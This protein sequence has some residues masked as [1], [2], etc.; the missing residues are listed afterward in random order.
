MVYQLIWALV[1]L[2]FITL[3]VLVIPSKKGNPKANKKIPALPV[4]L[5][6]ISVLIL[7]YTFQSMKT[8][9]GDYCQ[10]GPLFYGGA[11]A[12]GLGIL[13]L[14]VAIFNRFRKG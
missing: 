13:A 12:I 8:C 4:A 2:G 14:V 6:V 11:A 7:A 10:L 5:L 1:I 9:T 3:A